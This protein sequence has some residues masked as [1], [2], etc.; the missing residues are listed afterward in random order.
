MSPSLHHKWRPLSTDSQHSKQCSRDCQMPN[1]SFYWPQRN[2]HKY[3]STIMNGFENIVL[4]LNAL[5]WGAWQ[6]H[7]PSANE[8]EHK[9]KYRIWSKW[10]HLT[11][12]NMASWI[13]SDRC[14]I[15]QKQTLKMV[16]HL[17]PR[18][19]LEYATKTLL[20]SGC[21]NHTMLSNFSLFLTMFQK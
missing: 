9:E 17:T 19:V 5:F 8:G 3:G 10:S 16:Y 6:N 15:S 1:I 14:L 2:V 4:F 11:V 20:L 13:F 21:S 7:A 12:L 18:N